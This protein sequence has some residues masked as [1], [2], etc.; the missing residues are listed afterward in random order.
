MAIIYVDLV[1]DITVW[2]KIVQLFILVVVGHYYRSIITKRTSLV[3]LPTIPS[4]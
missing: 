3:V 4:E 1:V 2:D